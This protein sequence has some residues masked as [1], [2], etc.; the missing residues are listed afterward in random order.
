MRSQPTAPAPA[1]PALSAAPTAAEQRRAAI[2][3]TIAR[4]D[5]AHTPAPRSGLS[6]YQAPP[7]RDP[8]SDPA[9]DAARWLG[10]L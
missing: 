6:P 10:F 5:A 2:L 4:L 8:L 3:A 1:A 7:N 9:T